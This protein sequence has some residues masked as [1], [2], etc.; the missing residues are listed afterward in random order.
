MFHV[1]VTICSTECSTLG[2]NSQQYVARTNTEFQ[3]I[4]LRGVS[5]VVASGDSGANSR[6]N[7]SC[8]D[9]TLYPG[10]PATSSFVTAVGGTQLSNPQPLENPPALCTGV[11][12]VCAAGTSSEE[13]VSYTVAQYV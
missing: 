1:F 4:G 3:K 5:I 8:A 12:P 11:S 6:S 2:V 7:P 13:A 10:Y 9:A